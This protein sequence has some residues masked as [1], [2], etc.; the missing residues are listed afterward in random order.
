LI[1]FLLSTVA[2]LIANAVGLLIAVLLLPGFVIN[3][4]SFIVAVAIFS[5]VQTILGPFI[6]KLSFKSF[7]QL[8]GG[9][10]LVTIF[11]GLLV[12]EII[13]DGMQIGGIANW[14]AAT[15]LVW[16]GSLIAS[17][18]LPL[19]VFTQ[20]VDKARDNARG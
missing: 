10:A 13:M 7:P 6:T 15:L 20:L 4:M 17:I 18:L 2:Y 19:Y 3:P 16:L 9:I 8:M 5:L 1:R 11:V 14:L 12:T